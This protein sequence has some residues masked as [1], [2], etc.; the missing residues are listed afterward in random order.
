MKCVRPNGDCILVTLYSFI[1][2]AGPL[3]LSPTGQFIVPSSCPA[4]LLIAFLS[5]N[6]DEA[7]RLLHRYQR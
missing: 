7:L 4:F 2:E 5:E 3:M 1:R 6:L